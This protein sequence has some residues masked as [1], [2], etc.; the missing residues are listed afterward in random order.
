VSELSTND[1]R[2]IYKVREL[3]ECGSIDCLQTRNIRDLPEVDAVL[4]LTDKRQPIASDHANSIELGSRNP[5]PHFH[6]K[7]VEST[8]NNWLIRLYYTIV[9]TLARYQFICYVPDI[10]SKIQEEHKE[11]LNLIG[12]GE[13]DAAKDSL[14]RHIDWYVN[15]LEQ[16]L[17]EKSRSDKKIMLAAE[18]K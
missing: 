1:C 8:G 18:G 11:V 5:F 15:F 13:Y 16:R 3:I 12:N 10:F 4:E 2:N 7:L 6:I 17:V 9:P 14:K